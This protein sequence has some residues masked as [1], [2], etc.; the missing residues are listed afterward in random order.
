M[1]S[2]VNHLYLFSPIL[3]WGI[4][5]HDPLDLSVQMDVDVNLEYLEIGLSDCAKQSPSYRNLVLNI[6]EQEIDKTKLCRKI[7][8]AFWISNKEYLE[9]N[10]VPWSEV[11]L[12]ELELTNSIKEIDILRISKSE[13][14]RIA[15][16]YF[17]AKHTIPK[18]LQSNNISYSYFKLIAKAF[19]KIWRKIK[20]LQTQLSK[21]RSPDYTNELK[22]LQKYMEDHFG[23]RITLGTISKEIETRGHELRRISKSTISMLLKRKLH[24][25]YKK[26]VSLRIVPN[27]EEI[28]RKYFESISIQLYLHKKN[29]EIIYVDEFSL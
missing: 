8:Q 23:E 16:D 29:I 27:I 22:F 11:S 28:K 1:A 2:E 9:F 17:C 10:K 24:Y 18:V 19:I 4:I 20:K 5:N 15:H 7:M 13:F 12:E 25:S 26:S 14:W 3:R 6:W 21:T